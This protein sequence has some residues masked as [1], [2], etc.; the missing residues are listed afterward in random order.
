[1][2]A[3]VRLKFEQFEIKVVRI[4]DE[5]LESQK[6][7]LLAKMRKRL[8]ADFYFV[9]K[10]IKKPLAFPWQIWQKS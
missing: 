7:E 3:E 8:E 4:H 1:M 5:T 10:Q 9:L 6:L 2:A